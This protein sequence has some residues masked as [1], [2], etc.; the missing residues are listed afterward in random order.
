LVPGV[1][2]VVK[3]RCVRAARPAEWQGRTF[4]GRCVLVLF[5]E[6]LLTVGL[7]RRFDLCLAHSVVIWSGLSS[8][9]SNNA[10]TTDEMLPKLTGWMTGSGKP[11]FYMAC[12]V[13]ASVKQ[14]RSRRLRG[15][16]EA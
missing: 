11:M 5:R 4:D 14:S 8:S 6:G 3:L 12:R 16:E 13:E 10:M 9:G 7:G 2:T 15:V 1:I